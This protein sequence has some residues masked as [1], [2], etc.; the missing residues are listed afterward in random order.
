[1]ECQY[2]H[3]E[4]ERGASRDY[5]TAEEI[6]KIIWL[7]ASLGFSKVKIT[8]GEPLLRGDIS[9]IVKQIRTIKGITD[10]SMT[11]NGLLLAQK[12]EQLKEAGLDRV[13]VS[14][15]TINRG[16]YK[17]IT[18]VD[19]V[20]DVLRGIDAAIEA[21]FNPVKINMVILKDI[22]Q[23]EIKPM[24]EWSR[25]KQVILQ[26]IELIPMGRL[27]EKYHV[28]LRETERYLEQISLKIIE[29]ELHKRKKYI[30]DHNAE[31]EVVRPVHNTE[32]CANCTRL[33]VTSNG[34][35]KP[36]LM[37]N[38]NLQDI[39][40]PL[41]KGATDRQLIEIFKKAVELRRPYYM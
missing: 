8:G 41:R 26:L 11:T 24:I 27:Y 15:D 29:R 6:R 23:D 34:F 30:L 39:I 20:T 1:M 4:G 18:G 33:R 25:K 40:T 21:G 28:D 17:L 16:K 5:M 32:F 14:L 31:V 36:C 10:I 19:R 9:D 7:S 22:N 35:L 37:R 3:K 13:N 38:D 2:C 12:A